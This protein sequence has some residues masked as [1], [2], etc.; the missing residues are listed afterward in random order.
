MIYIHSVLRSK[1][2]SAN[3]SVCTK[4]TSMLDNLNLLSSQDFAGY[5]V[6]VSRQVADEDSAKELHTKLNLQCELEFIYTPEPALEEE[7]TLIED[8]EELPEIQDI[9]E[10]VVDEYPGDTE[11]EEFTYLDTEEQGDL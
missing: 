11:A 5:S 10:E 9:Q 6:A 8:T 2:D 1:A 3:R 4:V 7:T